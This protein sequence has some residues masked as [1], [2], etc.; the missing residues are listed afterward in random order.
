MREFY[1]P[2][3]IQFKRPNLTFTSSKISSR[4]TLVD[5]N[6]TLQS[7]LPN[8]IDEKIIYKNENELITTKGNK[9]HI[10]FVKPISE[11]AT[12]NGFFD[13]KDK[14]KKLLEDKNWYVSTTI[15]Q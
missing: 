7:L 11:M 15:T 6:T 9:T 2:G 4:E 5:K 10:Y 8:S 13:C 1:S 3:V 14:D 12:A